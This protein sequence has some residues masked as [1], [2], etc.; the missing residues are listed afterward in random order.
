MNNEDFKS[1][2][3]KDT[4]KLV[5]ELSKPGKKKSKPKPE[6][7]EGSERPAGKGKGAGKGAGK[8]EKGAGKGSKE[9]GKAGKA[10]GE[11]AGK[12]KKKGQEAG[13]KESEYRDRAKERQDNQDEYKKIAA[14]F[15]E[16][17]EVSLEESKYLGGDLE[18]THMVKGLDFA[19]LAKV[20]AEQNK[21]QQAEDSKQVKQ[22]K[23][24]QFES[25]MAKKVWRAL[26]STLHPHHSTFPQRY[27]KMGQ[28]LALGEK[29]RSAPTVFLPGRMD[30]EFSI[31]KKSTD[32][33]IPRV[34]F[35]SKEDAPEVDTSR[36]VAPVAAEVL[37]RVRMSMQKA[38]EER[39]ARKRAKSTGPTS[40]S[41]YAIAQKVEVRA[42]SKHRAQDADNDIFAGI[43][44]FSAEEVVKKARKEQAAKEKKDQKPK[45]SSYFDDVGSEKYLRGATA[46]LDPKELVVGD[47]GDE[48]EE[49]VVAEVKFK[50]SDRFQGAKR[51][52]V[53][54]LG[55]LGLGYYRDTVAPKPQNKDDKRVTPASKKQKT[56]AGSSAPA[57]GGLASL[58]APRGQKK[59]K[60]DEEN[61]DGLA[62]YGFDF[63]PDS[64]EDS[65]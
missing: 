11:E 58:R 20:R 21:K 26:V 33:D 29:F 19:L 39:K 59:P 51:G 49:D 16:H 46:Q 50:P 24:Q 37:D 43:G 61:E 25:E 34:V 48:A 65:G 35:S 64:G 2:L 8:A 5:E 41:S 28:A 57:S 6:G 55:A 23:T 22:Q 3:F 62:D 63:D 45:G 18:H 47:D 17:A 1:L 30:Y 36:K 15:E 9:G 27:K 52:F 44:S 7:G 4:K 56:G 12:G 60:A 53:F 54:K 40:T 14:E 10:K 31:G 32:A 38:A 42:A 13:P